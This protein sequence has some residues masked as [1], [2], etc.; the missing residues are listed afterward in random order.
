M[1][2]VEVGAGAEVVNLLALLLLPLF[3]AAINYQLDEGRLVANLN[4][5]IP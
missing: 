2:I 3:K 4:E 5:L 1:L